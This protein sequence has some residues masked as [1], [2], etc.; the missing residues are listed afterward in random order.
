MKDNL[1]L[2]SH[3]VV[4]L[5]YH[6]C[7]GTEVVSL[8]LLMPG[9]RSLN[10]SHCPMWQK[11]TSRILVHEGEWHT[12]LK[13][14]GSGGEHLVECK[15]SLSEELH[16]S[17]ALPAALCSANIF[18]PTAEWASGPPSS[19]ASP[20]NPLHEALKRQMGRQ[21]KTPLYSWYSKVPKK[22][23]SN[24]SKLSSKVLKQ[25]L[26]HTLRLLFSSI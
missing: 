21:K 5:S 13:P 7:L 4:V 18:D 25:M 12:W 24:K 20:P 14:L 22:K 2:S 26:L 1:T 23:N 10:S 9:D 11:V 15:E 19:P 8:I 6:P 3:F 17:M 16:V